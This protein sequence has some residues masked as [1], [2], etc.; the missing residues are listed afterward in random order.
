MMNTNYLDLV[1]CK[2]V[3]GIL[4]EFFSVYPYKTIISEAIYLK[5][6]S[7]GVQYPKKYYSSVYLEC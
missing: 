6:I 7:C 2:L 5:I 1:N 4:L 3:K